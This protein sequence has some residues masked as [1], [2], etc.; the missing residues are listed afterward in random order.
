MGYRRKN[1]KST[2]DILHDTPRD[3]RKIGPPC[4]SKICRKW[5]TRNCLEIKHEDRMQIFNNFWKG[6][7]S[8]REK[9]IFILNL[10][11]KIIPKQRTTQNIVSR[12]NGTYLYYLKIGDCK[13]CV[14]RNMFL[15]TFGLKESTVR[16]WLEN[17][18]L[19]GSKLP[20][21]IRDDLDIIDDVELE[22]EV[23]SVF[24]NNNSTGHKK[25][26]SRRARKHK[27]EYLINFF[28]KLPKLPSHYCRQS[29]RKLYLQTEINSVSHL[30]NIYCNTC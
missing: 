15:S 16:Y 22:T 5:K 7:T 28:N 25:G 3:E 27:N 29:T 19:P 24:E 20:K 10:I 11:E 17:K 21:H 1:K 4:K 12:R 14:C 9:Q 13:L 30:Y 8:W 6:M 23:D 26:N 2:L 18:I